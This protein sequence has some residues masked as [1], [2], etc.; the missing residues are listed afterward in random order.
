MKL[1]KLEHAA[2]IIE[3]SG[4]KLFI[5]PGSFTTA[6]TET[7]GAVAVVITHE[8]ADHW[9]PEQLGRIVK[10]NSD[11]RIFAPAGVAR[12]IAAVD[13]DLE[14]TSVQAG[15]TALVAPFTLRFFGATHAV[16]HES[17]PVVDNVGVL[18]NDELYYAGDAFTIP[19][20][21]DVG[22]L[23]VPAAAPWMKIS[24]AM[25][26]VLAV[27]PKRSFP[28]HEMLLSR[29]G[30]DLSNARIRNVTEQGG[31]EFFPLEPGDSL[32]L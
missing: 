26:Y 13:A 20:G 4:K 23:A 29:A 10:I 8:H 31:G 11:L 18:V 9:T 30:K 27:K 6:L 22:T 17:I 16:I 14:V 3:L 32:D 2:L 5:D 1:T 25:D 19:E 21:V 24:E 15:D 28:T 7:A 12:A